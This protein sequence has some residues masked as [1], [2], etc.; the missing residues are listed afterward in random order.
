MKKI[1]LSAILGL[2][3]IAGQAQIVSSTSSRITVTHKERTPSLFLDLGAGGFT[4]D[5]D[6]FGVDLGL[7][8]THMFSPSIGW[9]VLKVSAQSTID[10]PI[11]DLNIQAKTGIRGVS[12]VLFGASGTVYANFAGG[13]GYYTDIEEGGFAWE[14]GAGV[15]FNKHISLGIVYNSCN[16]S[17]D[18]YYGDEDVKVGLVSL[19]LGIGF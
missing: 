5:A 16:Y 15:N 11:D 13:Y 19:R 14:I 3:A 2:F 7:R 6:G 4:G 9:D 1:F 18:Y 10:E 8:W 12:P 17:Y